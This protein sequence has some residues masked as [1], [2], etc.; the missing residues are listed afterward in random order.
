MTEGG[1]CGSDGGS[2]GGGVTGMMTAA[3]KKGGGRKALAA[4][5]PEKKFKGVKREVIKDVQQVVDKE[6]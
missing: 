1:E 6:K 2:G 5:K 4:E 3:A